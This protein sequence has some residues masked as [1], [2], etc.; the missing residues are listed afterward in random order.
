MLDKVRIEARRVDIE[1]RIKAGADALH[2]ASFR[3]AVSSQGISV[4]TGMI[5]RGGDRA[6]RRRRR[7]AQ[8]QLDASQRG[9]LA[10]PDAA[11]ASLGGVV[12]VQAE[13]IE[14]APGSRIDVSGLLGGGVTTIG[15]ISAPSEAA[16]AADEAVL[17][18][19][20]KTQSLMAAVTSS[21]EAD[22]IERGDG[23][24]I[25]FL[26]DGSAD[27]GGFA[28]ARGGAI[29]GRGGFVEVSG[30]RRVQVY[31]LVDTTAA[32]ASW[33]PCSSTRTA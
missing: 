7:H 2:D 19:A 12:T 26:S 15:S 28:G 16:P 4:A 21:V 23:G 11:G 5:E 18:S 32:R 9:T 1:G 3:A 33:A 17:P 31:G 22:A 24:R 25:Q 8:G 13:R 6:D 30:R 20:P 27:F 29:L 10:M 14:L